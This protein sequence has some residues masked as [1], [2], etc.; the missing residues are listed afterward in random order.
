VKIV[1]ESISEAPHLAIQLILACMGKRRMADVVAE[2]ESFSEF[3]IETQRLSNGACDLRH[4]DG[5]GKPVMGIIGNARRKNLRFILKPSKSPRMDQTIA[6]AF[7]LAAV[8]MRQ[9]GISPASA[10]LHRKTQSA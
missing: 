8:W 10:L 2:R 3:F 6:I 7:E 9:F 1:V 5:M 4:F